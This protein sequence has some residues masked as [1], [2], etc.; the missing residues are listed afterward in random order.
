MTADIPWI[1]WSLSRALICE[2]TAPQRPSLP[3]VD[4]GILTARSGIALG[5]QEIAWASRRRRT[6]DDDGDYDQDGGS[7][8]S[9]EKSS[10]DDV[11]PDDVGKSVKDDESDEDDEVEGVSRMP[12]KE[13]AAHIDNV[14]S[15]L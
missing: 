8:G 6:T 5:R 9:G 13:S 7:R 1:S 2:K 4:T 10:S 11:E 14:S 3:T 12:E 15:K